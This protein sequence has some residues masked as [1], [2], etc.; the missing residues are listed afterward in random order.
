MKTQE[1]LALARDAA[2]QQE[3]QADTLATAV[4]A[5]QVRE[6][7]QGGGANRSPPPSLN[8]KRFSGL[9][10]HP[11]HSDCGPAAPGKGDISII[12]AQLVYI[13]AF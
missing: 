1:A 11:A 5:A 8:K 13:R 4:S 12:I 3:E 2:A 9:A 7:E 6:P 10:V